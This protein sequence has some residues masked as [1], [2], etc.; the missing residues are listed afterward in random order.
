MSALIFCTLKPS[1]C[2]LDLIIPN[3][4]QFTYIFRTQCKSLKINWLQKITSSFLTCYYW[5]IF[6]FHLDFRTPRIRTYCFYKS[7]SIFISILVTYLQYLWSP[8]F[9]PFIPILSPG[10]NFFPFGSSFSKGLWVVEPLL[11]VFPSFLPCLSF[12]FSFLV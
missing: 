9:S 3:L 12:L 7:Q 6:C 4:N 1:P 8:L 11:S 5:V 10:I 2:T